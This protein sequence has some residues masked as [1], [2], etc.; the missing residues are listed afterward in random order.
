VLV[1]NGGEV[2]ELV[3]L[4]LLRLVAARVVIIPALSDNVVLR[5]EGSMTR[6]L[7]LE[8]ISRRGLTLSGTIEIE[9]REGSGTKVSLYLPLTTKKARLLPEPDSVIELSP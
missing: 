5:E 9:S 4:G 2:P 8:E 1:L 7:L 3:Q 6:R